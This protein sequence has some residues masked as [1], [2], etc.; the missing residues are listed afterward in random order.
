MRT[1]GRTDNAATAANIFIVFA[2]RRIVS[3]ESSDQ[4]SDQSFGTRRRLLLPPAYGEK[5]CT[6]WLL[7]V[8]ASPRRVEQPAAR[9]F[10]RFPAPCVRRKE[11]LAHC[12]RE[13]T[14]HCESPP[15]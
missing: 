7:N 13:R 10:P 4:C 9:N 6:D 12:R 5:H 14:G 3:V 2:S 8:N 1:R 15:R 11:L